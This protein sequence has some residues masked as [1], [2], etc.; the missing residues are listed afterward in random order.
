MS[1]SSQSS[2]CIP[3]KICYFVNFI[4][5]NTHFHTGVHLPWFHDAVNYWDFDTTVNH[6]ILDLKGGRRS[7]IK[8]NFRVFPGPK[9]NALEF[10][11][12]SKSSMSYVTLGDFSRTC[13]PNPG[14]CKNGFTITFWV[15]L[16]KVLN[17]GVLLQLGLRR[18]SR[19]ITVNTLYRE[20]RISLMF[21][22]NTPKKVN[23]IKA[24]L[25]PHIWHHIALVWNVTAKPKMSVF[26]NCTRG[27][28]SKFKTKKFH[29]KKGEHKL[30]I[31][32]ANHGGKKATPIAVDDLAIWYK[33][34]RRERLCQM[35]NQERGLSMLRLS[36]NCFCFARL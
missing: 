35:I 14:R 23:S 18:K 19:G 21:Y 17:D 15:N 1:I 2:S 10:L 24:E 20:G 32:G 25:S 36:C 3:R 16:K 13:L 33:S 8:G 27:S 7:R 6:T 31:L 26:V 30:L 28:N 29:K 5:F 4:K 9:G 22:S 12:T 11:Q 34:L